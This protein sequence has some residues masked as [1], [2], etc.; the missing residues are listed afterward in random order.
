MPIHG[1][2]LGRQKQDI[3]P[4]A[5]TNEKSM[6]IRSSSVLRQRRGTQGSASQTATDTDCNGLRQISRR[7]VETNTPDRKSEAT[8]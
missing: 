8:G 1:L 2:L 4:K 3:D 7:R 6:G 5:S